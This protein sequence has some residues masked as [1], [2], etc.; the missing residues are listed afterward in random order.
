M[1][2]LLIKIKKI[3]TLVKPITVAIDEALKSATNKGITKVT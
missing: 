1:F 3:N 2:S